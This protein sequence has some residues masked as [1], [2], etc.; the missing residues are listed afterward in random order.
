M[1]S[2]GRPNCAFV[3]SLAQCKSI[4]ITGVAW[5][6]RDVADVSPCCYAEVSMRAE[7]GRA[8]PVRGKLLT[9]RNGRGEAW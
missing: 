1:E 2:H 3:P 6:D 8:M 5:G 4:T 9:V 7:A